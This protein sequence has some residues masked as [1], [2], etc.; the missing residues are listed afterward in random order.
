MLTDLPPSSCAPARVLTSFYCDKLDDIYVLAPV[1]Q[2]LC[3]LS[4]L[5]T[6]GSGETAQVC[7]A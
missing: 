4:A 1:L 6:F 7:Q 3:V 2:G 5:P